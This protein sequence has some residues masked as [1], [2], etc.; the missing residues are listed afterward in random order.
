MVKGRNLKQL[1]KDRGE[2]FYYLRVGNNFLS[3]NPE[4]ILN[5]TEKLIIL[6][7]SKYNVKSPHRHTEIA[8]CCLREEICN[9]YS[10]HGITTQRIIG[11]AYWENR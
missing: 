6:T 5:V 8:K 3:M 7:T 9:T 1:G 11:K 10:S 4:Q 2:H